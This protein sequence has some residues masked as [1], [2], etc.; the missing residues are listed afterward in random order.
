[1]N[2]AVIRLDNLVK[3]FAAREAFDQIVEPDNRVIHVVPRC[4]LLR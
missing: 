2:D 4:S 3:R 1:M